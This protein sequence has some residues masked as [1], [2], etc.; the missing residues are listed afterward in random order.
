MAWATFLGIFFL[1][2]NWSLWPEASFY[3]VTPRDELCSLGSPPPMGAKFWSKLHPL[4]RAPVKSWPLWRRQRM[5]VYVCTYLNVNS[6][7]NSFAWKNNF[8]LSFIYL[9]SPMYPTRN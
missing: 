7:Q 2:R 6:H 8:C 1:K 4:G 3:Y 5:N 9:P